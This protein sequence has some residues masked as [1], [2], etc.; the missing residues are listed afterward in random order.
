ML[1]RMT[2]SREQVAR[3]TPRERRRAATQHEILDAALAVMAEEGVAGLNLTRVAAR[4]G[5]RQP[6]LY[7]YFASRD[8]VYDALFERGML[9]HLRIVS[10]AM[11]AAPA[12]GWPAVCAGAHATLR[13]TAEQ[14]VLGELL[15]RPAVP[16][17]R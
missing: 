9:D 2:V 7:Q 8:A 17:F 16:G 14:P 13:F 3:T 1:N 15:F 12:P 10:A 11:D 5:L 6:S 4:V